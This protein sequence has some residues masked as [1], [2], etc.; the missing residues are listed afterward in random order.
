MKAD[1]GGEGVGREI[2][3]CF[4]VCVFFGV[5]ERERAWINLG[6]QT[7]IN[8][9]WREKK[10]EEKEKKNLVCMCVLL[11]MYIQGKKRRF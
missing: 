5:R 9:D 11:F 6:K 3:N 4:C 2:T 8:W 1:W 7:V 10:K